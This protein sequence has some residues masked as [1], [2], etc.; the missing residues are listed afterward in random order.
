[1]ELHLQ[2]FFHYYVLKVWPIHNTGIGSG[3]PVQ[4]SL[5]NRQLVRF[6]DVGDDIRRRDLSY[7]NR[8]HISRR[9]AGVCIC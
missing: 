3:N 7:G 2:H 9:D 6:R 1:L 8:T 5:A 4:Y